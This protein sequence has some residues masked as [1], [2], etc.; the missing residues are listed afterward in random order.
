MKQILL[1]L[2]MFTAY[3]QA[4]ACPGCESQQPRILR[5]ITHGGG[6]QSEWDYLIISVTI[7]IVLGTLFFSV[8]WLI[9][10]GEKEDDHIKRIVLN[11]N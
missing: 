5:G 10:P 7:V 6:P 1:S 8:K 3:I 2:I 11:F 4:Y 9:K